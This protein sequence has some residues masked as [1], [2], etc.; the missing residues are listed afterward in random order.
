VCE[1]QCFAR[2][3]YEHVYLQSLQG[4]DPAANQD[5]CVD[6]GVRIGLFGV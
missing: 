3:M 4:K 5:L 1:K 6:Q 2:E